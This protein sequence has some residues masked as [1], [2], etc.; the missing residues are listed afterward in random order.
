MTEQEFIAEAK[1]RGKSREETLRKFR[2]L[3]ASGAFSNGA[4]AAEPSQPP[5]EDLPPME[6][7]Q[8]PSPQRD[9]RETA[10]DYIPDWMSEFAAA[11]N[12]EVADVVDFLGPNGINA[13]LSLAGSNRRVPTLSS[14]KFGAT[15]VL[16]SEGLDTG[17]E[18]GFMEPGAAREAVRAA[19]ALT[20][21]AGGFKS[22]PRAADKA[23]SMLAD[24]VG[25]G[26]SAVT[27]GFRPAVEGAQAVGELSSLR[28]PERASTARNRDAVRSVMDRTGDATS[29]GMDF[30]PKSLQ[31]VREGRGGPQSQAALQGLREPIVAMVRD[32]SPAGKAKMRKM[33]DIVDGSLRNEE[34]R[35]LNR[36]GDVVGESI[37]NRT[38]VL[39]QA[40]KAAGRRVNAAAKALEGEAVDVQPAMNQFISDLDEMGVGLSTDGGVS[41]SFEGS[42]IEGL[43]GIERSVS[44]LLERLSKNRNIDAQAVHRMK[45][46]IDE[47]V[48]Y[49]KKA[50]G[51]GGNTVRVMKA[52]RRN[53]DQALDQRFPAYKEANDRFSQT[54]GALDSLQDAAGKRIDLT[55]ENAETALG[56]LSRRVLGNA[57]SRQDLLRGLKM[58]DDVAKDV[59]ANPSKVVG[60]VRDGA[61]SASPRL[62]ATL[63]ELDDDLIKQIQFVSNLEEVFGTNAANSMLGEL[64][65]TADRVGDNVLMGNKAGAG[66]EL[67]RAGRDK[68]RGVNQENALKAFRELLKE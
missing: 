53:L 55:G 9:W 43:E 37:A 2:E 1:R 22:V 10:G 3:K 11:A 51:L 61:G 42:D 63:K 50:D 58:V 65:K 26:S 48:T 31:V 44:K 27:A 6:Q 24:L 34:F 14:T 54:R 56:T 16:G 39:L 41:W 52:L 20:T 46:Q 5:N 23:G 8:A 29:F 36:V 57:V 68:L 35:A 59:L 45:R 28:I 25:A 17:I 21:A 32:A 13:V 62:G 18:G 67:L 7:A 4:V 60:Q 30:D 15:P 40:N 12:R 33:L 66:L 47:T 38:R 49:G 19:G 64:Q